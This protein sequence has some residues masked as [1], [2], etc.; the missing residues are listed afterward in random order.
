MLKLELMERKF[1]PAGSP[2]VLGH[3]H[4]AKEGATW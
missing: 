1:L 2:N 4:P 3:V